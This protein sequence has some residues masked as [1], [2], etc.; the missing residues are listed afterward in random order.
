MPLLFS[1]SIGAV[2][3][4]LGRHFLMSAIGRWLGTGFPWGTLIINIVGSFLM[5]VLIEGF[6][7]KWSASQELRAFLTVGIL[8]SF[9]T[10]STFSLDVALL[11]ERGQLLP[12][13]VY[14]V[15]SILFSVGGLFAALYLMRHVVV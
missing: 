5:G 14:I 1:I 12:A 15:F 2:I 11:T 10:F 6:A 9:T 7:L 8:S 3:G 4:A 13:F